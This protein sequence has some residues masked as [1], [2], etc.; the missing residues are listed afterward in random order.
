MLPGQHSLKLIRDAQRTR[1]LAQDKRQYRAATAQSTGDQSHLAHKS[2]TTRL[3]ARQRMSKHVNASNNCLVR[4]EL[5][6]AHVPMTTERQLAPPDSTEHEQLA[7]LTIESVA[8]VRVADTKPRARRL[9]GEFEFVR[10]AVGAV[11]ALDDE[12]EFG[13][14]K[15]PTPVDTRPQTSSDDSSGSTDEEMDGW[16]LVCRETSADATVLSSAANKST[17]RRSW[18]GVV[19]R[20]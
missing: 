19:S 4:L 18:A 3:P 10:P 17:P 7:P 15:G 16:E 12:A 6:E 20:S 11:I 14:V 2:I 8:K 9:T 13:L 1:A 5:S